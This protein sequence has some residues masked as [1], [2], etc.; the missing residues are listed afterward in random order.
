M[1]MHKPLH[2]RDDVDRQYVSRKDGG[3]GHTSIE[4][5][6]DAS[7]QRLKEYIEKHEGGLITAIKNFTEN[8][9]AN[10]MSITR[11]QK[12]EEKK[13]FGRFNRLINNV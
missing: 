1:T 8:P 11:K 2:S 5:S 13:L 6:V 9:M 10:M 3:K 4:K 12:W 7:I